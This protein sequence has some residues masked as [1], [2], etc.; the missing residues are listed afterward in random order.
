MQRSI[1]TLDEDIAPYFYGNISHQVDGHGSSS[2]I[3]RFSPMNNLLR[4]ATM[5]AL[6]SVALPAHAEDMHAEDK[7]VSD[8]PPADDS[9]KVVCHSE[10]V[11]GSIM[12]RKKICKT[13][14]EWRDFNA[15]AV[16]QREKI[17]NGVGNISPSS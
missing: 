4:A 9:Q 14:A 2:R 6:L 17:L 13:K 3:E 7:A 5:A 16:R 8:T 15:E 10:A 12:A 1:S 11:T